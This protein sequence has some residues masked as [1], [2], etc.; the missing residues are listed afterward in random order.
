MFTCMSINRKPKLYVA[1]S[2]GLTLPFI[3]CFR[4]SEASSFH[5]EKLNV[6]SISDVETFPDQV[7]L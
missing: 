4:L 3:Y 7:N 5:R 6:S 2:Y 1:M